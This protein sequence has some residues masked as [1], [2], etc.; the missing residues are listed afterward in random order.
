[1]VTFLPDRVPFPRTAED[2]RRGENVHGR[3]FRG[4]YPLKRD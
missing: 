1:V 3:D 4:G 2:T